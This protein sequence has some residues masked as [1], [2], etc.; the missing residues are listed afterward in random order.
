[1]RRLPPELIPDTTPAPRSARPGY[2][3]ATY[4]FR[5]VTPVIGC[6]FDAKS[7]DMDTPIRGGTIRGLL[8][9][10]WRSLKRNVSLAELAR[11]ERDLWGST[12]E[13]GYVEVFVET[14]NQ[15]V[16][17]DNWTYHE[18]LRE[19]FGSDNMDAARY[20]LGARHESGSHAA[21]LSQ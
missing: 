14:T 7:C 18:K 12:Y 19:R 2:V 16:A 8:R 1:M 10:W 17:L 9:V 21:R 15:P 3:E 11:E 5:T 4:A 6:G 13:P 20:V